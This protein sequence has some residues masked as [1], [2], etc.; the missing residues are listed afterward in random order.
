M[1]VREPG[2]GD[3]DEG[4]VESSRDALGQHR[5]AGSGRAEEE[6]AALSLSARLLEGLARLP[7]SDDPSHLFLGLRLAA[8]VLEL[9]APVCVAGLEALD[10]RDP[11]RDHRSEEDEEVHEEEDRE[12]ERVLEKLAGGEERREGF[13]QARSDDEGRDE[14]DDDEQPVEAA[15]E[16]G[17]SPGDDVVLARALVLDLS[18]IHI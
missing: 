10:L 14:P 6:D 3:R 9:H 16:G 11:H 7:E 2:S 8:D 15:P 17:A 18:L 5:L 13:P 4:A 1:K 12:D